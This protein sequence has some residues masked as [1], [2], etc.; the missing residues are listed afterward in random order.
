M[1]LMNVS[2]KDILLSEKNLLFDFCASSGFGLTLRK[3]FTL[4][5]KTH[6][7]QILLSSDS[8]SFK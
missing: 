5:R 6:M 8:I 4:E 2:N 7:W 3:E 1:H